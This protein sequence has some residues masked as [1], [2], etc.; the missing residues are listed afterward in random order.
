MQMQQIRE[1]IIRVDKCPEMPRKG[2]RDE[3]GA[4]LWV[5]PKHVN[6]DRAEA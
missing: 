2:D 6:R 3:E 1:V 4:M 5:F